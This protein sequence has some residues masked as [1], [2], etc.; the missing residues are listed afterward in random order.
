VLIPCFSLRVNNI[1]PWGLAYLS[2]VHSDNSSAEIMY[3]CFWIS[4]WWRQCLSV[5]GDHVSLHFRTS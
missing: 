3:L 5:L 1:S 4:C 2:S